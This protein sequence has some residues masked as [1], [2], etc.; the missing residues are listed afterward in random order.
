MHIA[1]IPAR[2]GS[3]EFKHKNRLFFDLTAD[4]LD[5]IKWFD[6]VIV[7]IDDPIVAK[8]SEKRNYNVHRRVDELSGPSVSIKKVFENVVKEMLMEA[9]TILWLFCLPETFKQK[10]DFIETKKIIEQ[11]EVRSLCSFIPANTHPF[12]CW[13]YSDDTNKLEQY[14]P[15]NIFRRQDLP[16]A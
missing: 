5:P 9:D 7:S 10:A 6:D 11:K 16:E 8:Y 15:N 13:K 4:F 12:N 1:F 2:E 3:Q 14:I